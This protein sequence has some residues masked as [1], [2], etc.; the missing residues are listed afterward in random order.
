[1]PQGRW[2]WDRGGDTACDMLL[3]HALSGAVEG[4]ATCMLK[5]AAIKTGVWASKI[6]MSQELRLS[7]EE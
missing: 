6:R 5:S 7:E 1:M 2:L 4:S 3:E